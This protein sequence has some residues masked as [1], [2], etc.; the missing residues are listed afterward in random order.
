MPDLPGAVPLVHLTSNRY[1]ETWRGFSPGSCKAICE[2]QRAHAHVSTTRRAPTC[3]RCVVYAQ[4]WE[5]QTT[6]T[7][8][9]FSDGQ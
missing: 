8:V 4:F 1:K 6:L 3:L 9:R 5:P 7:R 2:E